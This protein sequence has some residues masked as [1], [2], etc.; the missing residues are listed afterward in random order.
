M[1]D[2]TGAATGRESVVLA[3]SSARPKLTLA[4]QRHRLAAASSS[5]AATPPLHFHRSGQAFFGK[6]SLFFHDF[7]E[8]ERQFPEN[9]ATYVVIEP[10]NANPEPP[11]ERWT[12]LADAIDRRLHDM[13]RYVTSASS[14]GAAREAG[15]GA[16]R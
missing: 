14:P 16:L 7:V 15:G 3:A 13:K 6:R 1:P 10:V 11:V 2:G 5:G 12:A 8:Y 4:R 9:D